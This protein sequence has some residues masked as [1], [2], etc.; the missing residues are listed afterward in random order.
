MRV[1]FSNREL[2]DAFHEQRTAARLWGPVVAARYATLIR[3]ILSATARA[4]IAALRR[5]RLHPLRGDMRGLW[6]MDLVGRW[7]LLV[8]FQDEGAL[9][10]EVS[11]HYD[12]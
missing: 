6:A 2:Y 9:V 5:L 8:T 3:I 11:N 4:D 7:R 12:D 1:A 10:Q